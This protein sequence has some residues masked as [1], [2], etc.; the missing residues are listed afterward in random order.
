MISDKC[1]DFSAST[2]SATSFLWTGSELNKVA[3]GL[4]GKGG[5]VRT[6]SAACST[7]IHSSL[8]YR[9]VLAALGEAKDTSLGAMRTTGPFQVAFL[10]CLIFL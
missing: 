1:P 2:I 4:H 10:G 5:G 8:G 6:C 7:S 3:E 9:K